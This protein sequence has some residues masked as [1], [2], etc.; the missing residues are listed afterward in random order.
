MTFYDI[1]DKNNN[2]WSENNEH[3]IKRRERMEAE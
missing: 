1:F 2:Q 3:R